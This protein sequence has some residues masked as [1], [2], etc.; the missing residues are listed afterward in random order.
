MVRR[1]ESRRTWSR[2]RSRRAI[3]RECADCAEWGVDDV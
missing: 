3:D 2:A 1:L